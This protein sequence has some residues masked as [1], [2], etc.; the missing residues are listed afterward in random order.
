MKLMVDTK[1]VIKYGCA[2]AII[3]ALCRKERRLSIEKIE[4]EMGMSEFAVRNHIADLKR[5]GK[6]KVFYNNQMA[7]KEYGKGKA[8][9]IVRIDVYDD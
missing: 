5:F 8:N 3:M 9:K 4:N 1:D 7:V 2:K 6:I